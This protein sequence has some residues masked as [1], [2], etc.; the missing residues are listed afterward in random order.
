VND[1]DISKNFSGADIGVIGG[2]GVEIY[3]FGIEAR[4]NWGLRNISDNGDTSDLK[5]F[6]FEL[7]G[8]FRF[9]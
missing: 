3:R 7:L 1:L 6:T 2:A 5:T 9:N 4:G 8:K